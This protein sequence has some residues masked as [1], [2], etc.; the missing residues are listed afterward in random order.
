MDLLDRVVDP[1]RDLLSRVDAALADSGAPAG[2]EVWDLV[3]RLGTLPGGALEFVAGLDPLALADTA[4]GLRA[5][6][7]KHAGARAT[8]DA[9]VAAT[10]WE[11]SAGTAMRARCDALA[12]YLG[13][14]EYPH[15]ESLAGRLVA[16][17]GYLDD[18][19]AW[20]SDTRRKVAIVLAEALGSAQAVQVRAG[21]GLPATAGAAGYDSPGPAALAIGV[22]LLRTVSEAV[23]DAH[24]LAD[25]WQPL[26]DQLPY[27]V[28]G[29]QPETQPSGSNQTRVEF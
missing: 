7:D 17:R 10:G 8:L 19:G 13:D 6:A 11:G 23:D 2:H 4:V 25:A 18:V 9:A 15:E 27:P 26:L 24:R 1:A 14:G 21:A 16:M 5:A 3:R 20:M 28:R 22:R 29:A 12:R